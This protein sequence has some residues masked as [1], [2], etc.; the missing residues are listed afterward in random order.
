MTKERVLAFLREQ[1]GY[2]SGQEMSRRLNLS[3]AAVWKAV[4]ALREDGY[5]ID[6]ATNRGYRLLAATEQLCQREILRVLGDHPWADRITV[7]E[8]VDST[9][10]LAKKLAAE[11]A[12]H[13]TVVVADRQTGGRGRMGRSFSSP[14]GVGVYL[15]VILRPSAP[16]QQLLHLTAVAAE[17]TV[18]AIEETVGLRPGIKWTNDVVLERR[19]C[20]GILTEMSIQAESG[21]VDYVV[22][23][24]GTNCNHTPEDFPEEVRPVAISLREA[25]GKA[26][27]RNAYAAA[28]ICQLYR[29]DQGLLTEKAAWLRRYAEDCVTI[30]QDVQVIRNGQVRP[31]HADGIDEDA[32]LLVTYPDGS[33]ETVS[34]GEVSV[35]GMYGYV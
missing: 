11:G 4:Q 1:D 7:L 15:T 12:P 8:S 21:L 22:V 24:I 20:V 23:G 2:V 19:K 25:T 5:A 30:G 33:K 29:A 27:D 35:R 14:P 31:A 26:V 6:S 17:A 18:E 10:T 3:R 34:S 16:P 28:L 9:N 13:G 32:G